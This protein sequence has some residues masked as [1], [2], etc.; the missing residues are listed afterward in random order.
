MGK[1]K[2]GSREE[3]IVIRMYAT[4]LVRSMKTRH[5]ESKREGEREMAASG[6]MGN[7]IIMSNTWQG[8]FSKPC[9]PLLYSMSAR[10]KNSFIVLDSS[11]WS[12][13]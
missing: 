1:K 4:C 7:F 8:L 12:E 6:K 3:A 9:M 5:M 2:G 10:K 13:N 11:G